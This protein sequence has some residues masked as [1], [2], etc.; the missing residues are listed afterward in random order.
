MERNLRCHSKAWIDLTARNV[1]EIF[2]GAG[3]VR[4]LGLATNVNVISIVAEYD[5]II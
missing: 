3:W 1:M 4:G 2:R 5:P